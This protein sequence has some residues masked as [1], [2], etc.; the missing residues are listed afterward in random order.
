DDGFLWSDAAGRRDP[1]L[2][3]HASQNTCHVTSNASTTSP[4]N[5]H[6]R[7]HDGFGNP[8]TSRFNT[9]R[10]SVSP[11]RPQYRTDRSRARVVSFIALAP[12]RLG[13]APG[14]ERVRVVSWLD[15]RAPAALRGS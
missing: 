12:H 8:K 10:A 1:R 15:G 9:A 7:S 14:L 11:R 13:R 2:S 4:S 3:D 6:P 5:S